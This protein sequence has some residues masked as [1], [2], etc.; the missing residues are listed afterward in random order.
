M[1][2]LQIT[3]YAD[4]A[5]EIRE[6]TTNCKGLPIKIRELTTNCK[7]FP[8][9]LV[10]CGGLICILMLSQIATCT[11]SN[12]YVVGTRIV[13]VVHHYPRMYVFVN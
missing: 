8:L 4:L 11:K 13:S 1:R 3:N 10:M 9:M 5:H 6:L 7:A 2:M 12:G